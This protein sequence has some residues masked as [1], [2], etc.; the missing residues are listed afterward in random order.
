MRSSRRRVKRAGVWVGQSGKLDKG[1]KHAG[2]LCI[3]QRCV[4][5]RDEKS[6]PRKRWG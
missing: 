1:R 5:R 4:G 3:C 6:R 2:G